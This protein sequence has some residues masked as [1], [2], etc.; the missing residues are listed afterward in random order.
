MRNLVMRACVAIA[1]F[2]NM[3]KQRISI[4]SIQYY[5]VST[6]GGCLCGRRKDGRILLLGLD[7]VGKTSIF[8][9]A[10]LTD[11]AIEYY[12]CMSPIY[13]VDLIF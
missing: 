2:N 3:R 5:I 1:P 13:I 11:V 8:F 7:G 12:Y 4:T 6:M 9:N 10:N